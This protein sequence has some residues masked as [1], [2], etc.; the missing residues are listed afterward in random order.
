MSFITVSSLTKSF[1]AMDLFTNI[2]FTVA[3]G[4]RLALVGPNGVGKTTLLRIIVGADEASSGEVHRARGARIGYLPQEADFEMSGTL[5]DACLHVFSELIAR[6]EELHRLEVQM[7]DAAQAESVML[8]YG[9]LQEEFERRGGYTYA[10]RIKQVLTGLGFGEADYTL[11]LDHLSGGQRTRAYLARLLLSNPDLL[12]LDEPTNHLDIAAVEWLE[13]YLA[14]WD[15]AAVVVSHDRYFLDKACN[16]ILEMHP[17]AFELY[18]GNYSAYLHQ[19]QERAERRQEIFESERDKLL[20]DMEYIKK[21]IA[22][23]NVQQAKGKLRRL[24]RI[25]QAIEQVGMDAVLNTNWSQLDVET[26]TSPFGVEEAEK[27]VRA[28]RSPVRTLPHLHLKLGSQKRSGELVIRTRDLQVGYPDKLLFRA[29]DIELRRTDCA[30]LIGPNGAGKTTFLKTILGQTEPLA[31]E[32]ILGASL[33]V[34]YFAQAHEGLNPNKTLIEEIDSIMPNWLPGQIRDY[35]GRYLFSGEDAY[36]KV[37]MLSGG[38]RG[39]LA[40]AKL[41]LQDTN[42][43][44]LDEPTNHLDIPSQEVLEAVLDD[45]AGTILLVTHDRYLVDALATQIWEVNP[46]ENQMTAFNGTYSQMKEEREK[47]AARSAAQEIISTPRKGRLASRSAPTTNR[48]ERRRL[49]QL[50][51]L[52]NTIT[53]LEKDLANLSAQ[54]ESPLV[55]ASEVVKISKE[56]ERIQKEMDEKLGEWEELQKLHQD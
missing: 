40:L 9:K 25:V 6:Q 5:W 45:Y 4:S 35:L 14:Q 19:R 38:E 44:L 54:L 8:R 13:S 26:T 10:T 17:G 55:S 43:L 23:Q 33:N 41:A 11:S 21:N 30:A 34:G 12:L 46:D 56:Y 31:G 20:K 22:G 29:P 3:K 42:L 27:H 7:A 37:S 51:E 15:G 16:V 48:E 36:K 24:T 53:A 2:S 1:G 32:V 50:Q 18:H 39:R 28:L 52:E 47:E 49:A